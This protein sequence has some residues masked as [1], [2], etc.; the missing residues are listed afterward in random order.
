MIITIILILRREIFRS[1]MES[2][3]KIIQQLILYSIDLNKKP[4]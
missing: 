1:P 2:D 3:T 4:S